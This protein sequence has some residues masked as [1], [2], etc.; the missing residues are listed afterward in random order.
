MK[1]KSKKTVKSVKAW[2]VGIE[3]NIL[4]SK[5]LGKYHIYTTQ[6]EAEDNIIFPCKVFSVLITPR[7]L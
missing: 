3:G 2:A 7:N 5:Q 4:F 1:N 6:K